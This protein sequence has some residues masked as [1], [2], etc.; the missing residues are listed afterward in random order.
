[1]CTY[2]VACGVD[3]GG[4]C[5]VQNNYCI[6]LS[7]P[8]YKKNPKTFLNVPFI[9]HTEYLSSIV[10]WN[11]KQKVLEKTALIIFRSLNVH[12]DAHIC[13]PELLKVFFSSVEKL[14]MIPSLLSLKILVVRLIKIRLDL[15]ENT[16]VGWKCL[17]SA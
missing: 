17:R 5:A 13:L 11:C 9:W 3:V 10:D 12:N 6:Y 8:F 7:P 2:C 14:E 1:M 4:V 16:Y 15:S